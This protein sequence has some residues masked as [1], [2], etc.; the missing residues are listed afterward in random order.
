MCLGGSV[1]GVLWCGLV[2][3]TIIRAGWEVDVFGFVRFGGVVLLGI[4][5]VLV[6]V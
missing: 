6:F 3:V 1:W 5:V 4:W 2:D